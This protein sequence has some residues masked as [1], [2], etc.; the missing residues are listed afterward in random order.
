VPRKTRLA[1]V[2]ERPLTDFEAAQLAGN[3]L[4]AAEAAEHPQAPPEDILAMLRGQLAETARV[5]NTAI[6]TANQERAARE[7]IAQELDHA[8]ADSAKVRETA[9]QEVSR[10]RQDAAATVAQIERQAAVAE[11][12]VAAAGAVRQAAGAIGAL[13]SFLIDRAPVLL[14]LA[15]AYLLARDILPQP[16]VTQLS[17]IAIYGA[18]AV[19]PAVWLSVRRQ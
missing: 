3:A 13:V 15:G 4:D 16:S 17:L 7:Q 12:A 8:K 2:N 5:A 14:T 9:I 19:A 1:L 18:V 10:A 6:E 11:R